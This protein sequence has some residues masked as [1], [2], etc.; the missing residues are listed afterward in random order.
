M[1]RFFPLASLALCLTLSLCTPAFA[2]DY[3][4]EGKAEPGYAKPTSVEYVYT[5]NGGAQA[6]EDHSKDAV[7]IP[8]AFGVGGIYALNAF[9][10]STALNPGCAVIGGGPIVYPGAVDAP[11]MQAATA[12]ATAFTEVTGSL[13]YA[14]GSLGTLSIP[15]LSLTVGIYEGTDSTA[16][17]KGAGHFS[18]T[19]IWNGN[20]A[21]AAHNRGVNNH[22]GE[23]H[24]LSIGDTITL[25]TALGTRTYQVTS[26]AKVGETDREALAAS[27]ENRITLY[28]CV[29]DQR[30]LRWCVQAVEVQ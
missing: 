26:V 4:F 16:L 28:T 13:Y 11:S 8:P 2:A 14:D 10:P 27:G 3:V 6:N 1:K 20:V 12:Q 24:T 18:A 29:R 19:S 21:L 22:F 7:L 30:D 5:A 25:T 9:G 23:I 17:A 15:A